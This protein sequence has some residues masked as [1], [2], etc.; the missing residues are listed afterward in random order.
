MLGASAI[1]LSRVSVLALLVLLAP[2]CSSGTDPQRTPIAYDPPQIVITNDYLASLE[3]SPMAFHHDLSVPVV[4]DILSLTGKLQLE[5]DCVYLQ[6]TTSKVA[7]AWPAA[8]FRWNSSTESVERGNFY[9]TTEADIEL[10][11]GTMVGMSSNEVEYDQINF[12]VKNSCSKDLTWHIV[13]SMG[14]R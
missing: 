9:E 13:G 3:A 14:S 12:L 2:A 8:T 11:I 10:P 5:E 7:L 6:T 4:E 1:K